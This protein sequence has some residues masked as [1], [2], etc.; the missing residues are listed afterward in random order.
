MGLMDNLPTIRDVAVDPDPEHDYIVPIGAGT[1]DP[2]G[3]N[4]IAPGLHESR[5]NL[6]GIIVGPVGTPEEQ[7][8]AIIAATEAALQDLP[9]A[10]PGV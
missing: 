5:G 3:P 6:H 2:H 8:T 4:C 10:E 7:R 9:A 1:E